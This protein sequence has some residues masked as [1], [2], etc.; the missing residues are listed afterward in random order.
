MEPKLNTTV[1]SP[2]VG[3]L[4]S[5]QMSFTTA[6]IE[7]QV[8]H[9]TI[10]PFGDRSVVAGGTLLLVNGEFFRLDEQGGPAGVP[11]NEGSGIFRLVGIADRQE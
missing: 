5:F 11:F 7:R 1:N 3:E 8:F 2:T 10:M 4:V 6:D 9:G